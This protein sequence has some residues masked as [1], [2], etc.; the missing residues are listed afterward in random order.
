M[1]NFDIVDLMH[2]FFLAVQGPVALQNTTSPVGIIGTGASNTFSV[3]F[4][5][6]V[7][8]HCHHYMRL[9]LLP[10]CRLAGHLEALTFEY[11]KMVDLNC[12][13]L[14]LCHPVSS[15]QHQEVVAKCYSSQLLILFN[16]P[17]DITYCLMQVCCVDS[18]CMCT[19][20]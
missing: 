6:E 7:T 20:S 12:W 1:C 16:L 14:M 5:Q 9:I 18:A 4:D 8:A 11:M 13:L 2:F 10:I 17:M 19:Y 3:G 15:F